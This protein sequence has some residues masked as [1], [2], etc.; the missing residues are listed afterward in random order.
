MP[1][2]AITA[3][4][5]LT[6]DPILRFTQAGKPVV[7]LTIACNDR[8]KDATTGE[9]VDGDTTFL[10]VT[11]WHNAEGIA[12]TL[13][14]GEQVVVV[15]TL[16]QRNYETKEGEKRRAFEVDAASVSKVIRDAA[17]PSSAGTNTDTSG[18]HNQTDE[19]PF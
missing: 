18:W 19:A 17:G 14:K 2:P 5:N 12:E 1:I 11:S 13:H 16:K 3:R 15:G 10:D 7:S 8:R 6:A 4:G 9:W